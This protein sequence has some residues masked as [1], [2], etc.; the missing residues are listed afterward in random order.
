MVQFHSGAYL[1]N[2][3]S[4]A[5]PQ[6][7]V[8]QRKENMNY[9]LFVET[10]MQELTN[11]LAPNVIPS[12]ERNADDGSSLGDF[13]V[14]SPKDKSKNVAYPVVSLKKC[15]DL[16]K[17]TRSIPRVIKKILYTIENATSIMGI[18]PEEF[19]RY[20][21][22]KSNI[23]LKLMNYENNKALLKGTPHFCYYDLALTCI[24]LA[25]NHEDQSI[26]SIL[27]RNQYLDMW[28]MTQEE[29]LK[30]AIENTTKRMQ[31]VIMPMKDILKGLPSFSVET[32]NSNMFILTNK[33]RF[34]GA[35]CMTFPDVLANFANE[36]DADLI[37]LP[38][39]THEII[40]IPDDG[41][42][43]DDPDWLNSMIRSVN[44]DI[45]DPMDRLSDHFYR[46]DRTNMKLL[47]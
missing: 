45:V 12:L 28:N 35:V 19:A 24:Y 38:S 9:K 26:Q 11:A 16:Y 22:V 47:Y 42:V 39:S 36:K 25:D 31:P 43:N 41:N 14:F 15:Y 37:I 5:I 6:A 44:E 40:V 20:E 8:I 32:D 30:Q 23:C 4:Q 29:L 33:E 34:L 2:F 21:N 46:F 7:Y 13:V 3:L 10:I 27:I 1:Y 18:S 17:S